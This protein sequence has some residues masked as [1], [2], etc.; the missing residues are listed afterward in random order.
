MGQATSAVQQRLYRYVVNATLRPYL[1]RDVQAD[2]FVFGLLTG[3]AELRNI[4]LNEKELN[5]KFGELLRPLHVVE[6]SVGHLKVALSLSA[7]GRSLLELRGLRLTLACME[8]D[9]VQEPASAVTV[10]AAVAA[11]HVCA[12]ETAS[13]YSVVDDGVDESDFFAP[14]EPLFSVEETIAQLIENLEVHIYGCTTTLTLPHSVVQLHLDSLDLFKSNPLAPT[15]TVTKPKPLSDG[16]RVIEIRG[17]TAYFTDT[18]SAATSELG[19]I[20]PLL[21]YDNVGEEKHPVSAKVTFLFNEQRTAL[22]SLQCS[23]VFPEVPLTVKITQRQLLLL[24]SDLHAITSLGGDSAPAVPPQ[25]ACAVSPSAPQPAGFNAEELSTRPVHDLGPLRVPD[26]LT[27]SKLESS[28]FLK[29]DLSKSILFT[30][31]PSRTVSRGVAKKVVIALGIPVFA[32][33]LE[34][35]AASSQ[36]PCAEAHAIT[37]VVRQLVAK[38]AGSGCGSEP[39]LR[40]SVQRA[41]AVSR[42]VASAHDHLGHET[43]MLLAGKTIF[44]LTEGET[45]ACLNVEVGTASEAAHVTEFRVAMTPIHLIWDVATTTLLSVI[46]EALSDNVVPKTKHQTATTT[47]TRTESTARGKATS[48]ITFSQCVTV[49][50]T[51]PQPD[52][53]LSLL[54]AEAT[55]ELNVYNLRVLREVE[56]TGLPQS[57]STTY[58]VF[59]QLEAKMQGAPCDTLLL[60]GDP[61]IK[62]TSRA[63]DA[64]SATAPKKPASPVHSH[65]PTLMFG[66]PGVGDPTQV[67]VEHT[68]D[69]SPS[70]MEVNIPNIVVDLLVAE[71]QSLLTLLG[72]LPN[73]RGM[74]TSIVNIKTLTATVRDPETQQSVRGMLRGMKAL[75]VSDYMGTNSSLARVFC[76]SLRV[77]HCDLKKQEQFLLFTTNIGSTPLCDTD[78]YA[79]PPLLCIFHKIKLQLMDGTNLITRP[80]AVSPSTQ[81]VLFL[82]KLCE[83][84]AAPAAYGEAGTAAPAAIAAAHGARVEVPRIIFLLHG[85]T[86]PA[87]RAMLLLCGVCGEAARHSEPRRVEASGFVQTI[88]LFSGSKETT[89]PPPETLLVKKLQQLRSGVL[90]VRHPHN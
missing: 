59:S 31:A 66:G 19:D 35:P 41:E 70:V 78:E 89:V 69:I 83:P 10:P 49:Q 23:V 13:E 67:D 32:V 50:L 46:S 64:T 37:L 80:F 2:D 25:S 62:L 14:S 54:T 71:V 17:V 81:A 3:T 29:P 77:T 51:L 65:T 43:V 48:R 30:L 6:G 22:V 42:K 72:R 84:L 45:G 21:L 87:D 76:D 52:L 18:Q 74:S 15:E 27:H 36:Q 28:M 75:F 26:S 34:I 12:N 58:I 73:V 85:T 86:H 8:Q 90:Q 7:G 5:T 11:L 9:D 40:L 39:P 38:I 61:L 16:F 20:V 44:Q 63:L 24:A 56:C 88:A 53:P 60:N 55:F 79:Y 68:K 1:R 82:R 4:A 47:D 57:N 33:E